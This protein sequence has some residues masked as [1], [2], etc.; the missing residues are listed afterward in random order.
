MQKTDWH[1]LIAFVETA[2]A[3]HLAAP[4]LPDTAE[5]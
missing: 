2:V 4:F 1:L 5:A 3:P